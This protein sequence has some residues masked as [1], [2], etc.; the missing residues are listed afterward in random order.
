MCSFRLPCPGQPHRALGA[1]EQASH[2]PWH[3]TQIQHP[4]Q[5]MLS[6]AETRPGPHKWAGTTMVSR[7]RPTARRCAYLWVLQRSA[8]I[9]QLLRLLSWHLVT[10]RGCSHAWIHSSPGLSKFA[11]SDQRKQTS[12]TLTQPV[13]PPEVHLC[14]GRDNCQAQH[15]APPSHT[16]AE[17]AHAVH[18]VLQWEPRCQCG[19]DAQADEDLQQS[20][21]HHRQLR[22]MLADSLGAA[23]RAGNAHA[24]GQRMEAS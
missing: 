14:Y 16:A 3:A 4:G 15:D 1:A 11:S 19:E 22:A 12:C 2:L 21:A 13:F 17:E 23:V 10:S 5:P 6:A 24:Q 8:N 9:G 7:A 18:A 20:S